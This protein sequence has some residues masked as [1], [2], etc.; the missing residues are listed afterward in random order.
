[1]SNTRKRFL[2]AALPASLVGQRRTKVKDAT[3]YLARGTPSLPIKLL[4]HETRGSGGQAIEAHATRLPSS[5]I[6]IGFAFTNSSQKVLD[7]ANLLRES[8]E[9]ARHDSRL[10]ELLRLTLL[11]ALGSTLNARLK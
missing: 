8:N 6:V 5:Q 1:M 3:R 9:R 2:P 10:Q 4:L 7:V 11:G